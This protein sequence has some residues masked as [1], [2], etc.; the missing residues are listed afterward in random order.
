MISDSPLDP[1]VIKTTAGDEASTN[2]FCNGMDA[3][4]P[5]PEMAAVV[6]RWNKKYHDPFVSDAWLAWDTAWV[7]HQ[8]V[9]KA[10]SLDAAA[11]VAAFDKMTNLGDVKTVF[12]PGMMAG[13]ASFGVNRVLAQ[14]I[15]ISRIDH[16]KISLVKL[17]LPHPQS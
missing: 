6:E 17:M 3:S 11:V 12:G 1:M 2:V 15:P 7:F 9:I 8:A 5:T 10:D 16:G 13:K 14:P 4:S